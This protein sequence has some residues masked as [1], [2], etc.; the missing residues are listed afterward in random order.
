MIC[1]R[2]Y[3]YRSELCNSRFRT[4]LP[5]Q[6]SPTRYNSTDPNTHKYYIYALYNTTVHI[7]YTSLVNF[8][9]RAISPTID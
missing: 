5:L 4:H 7:I 9:A 3:Y 6:V 1:V 2:K 8:D